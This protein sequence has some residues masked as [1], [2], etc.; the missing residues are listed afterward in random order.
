MGAGS[1]VT[2]RCWVGW[3]GLRAQ[4]TSVHNITLLS[5]ATPSVVGEHLAES[6]TQ[7]V[8]VKGFG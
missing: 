6:F 8:I 4:L 1:M 3:S 5:W 2:D 7:A